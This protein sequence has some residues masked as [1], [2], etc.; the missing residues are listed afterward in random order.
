MSKR[1]NSSSARQD[2]RE[3][4]TEFNVPV[5]RRFTIS[6]SDDDDQNY[7]I[8]ASPTNHSDD[9]IDALIVTEIIASNQRY[10]QFQVYNAKTKRKNILNHNYFGRNK[11]ATTN[12]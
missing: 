4:N 12:L 10:P 7:Q 11:N 1:P 8:P 2:Y 6:Y 9:E 5:R 3:L